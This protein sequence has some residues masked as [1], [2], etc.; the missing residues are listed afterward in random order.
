MRAC[1]LFLV[2]IFAPTAW[3]GADEDQID[4]TWRHPLLKNGPLVGHV[5]MSTANL[6]AHQGSRKTIT[7]K[8]EKSDGSGQQRSTAMEISGGG[9]SRVE[10]TNLEPLTTYKYEMFVEGQRVIDDDFTTAPPKDRSRFE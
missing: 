2:L 10:L 3:A 4:K 5:T 8:Y 9:Y 6:W 7:V 1:V